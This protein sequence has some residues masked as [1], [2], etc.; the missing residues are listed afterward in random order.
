MPLLIICLFYVRSARPAVCVAGAR[1]LHAV[2]LFLDV[3]RAKEWRSGR[4][5]LDEA[6]HRVALVIG[7]LRSIRTYTSNDLRIYIKI[8]K[9]IP[10]V[11]GDSLSVVRL[12]QTVHVCISLRFLSMNTARAELFLATR[13]AASV[14]ALLVAIFLSTC[15]AHLTVVEARTR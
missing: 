1:R 2:P 11:L 13:L 6:R 3:C 8:M 15:L 7:Q 5:V 12:I 4:G 10:H 9:N 14:F